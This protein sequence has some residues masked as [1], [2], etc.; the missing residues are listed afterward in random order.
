M[1]KNFD[2]ELK[3]ISKALDESYKTLPDV[4]EENNVLTDSLL[5]K[6]I[7]QAEIQDAKTVKRPKKLLLIAAVIL[8]AGLIVGCSPTV[9]AF[10]SDV[11]VT[12][13]DKC[14][15]FFNKND[16]CT[17]ITETY[18][19][20][21]IP[22]GYVLVQKTS[23]SQN[24]STKTLYSNSSSEILFIQG[25]GAASFDTESDDFVIIQDKFTIY[26]QTKYNTISAAWTDGKYNFCL[27]A[28]CSV[29]KNDII[30]MIKSIVKKI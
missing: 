8:V 2:N 28:D 29:S 17:E 30:A 24:T 1:N 10:V 25:I 27:H 12:L 6:A 23:N 7:K 15:E 19:L 11:I 9:R 3:K 13:K 21:W 18:E 22:D 26:L 14:V 16:I 5:D 20:G 4:P